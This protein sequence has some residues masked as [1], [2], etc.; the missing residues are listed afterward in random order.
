MYPSQAMKAYKD[1]CERFGIEVD[2]D[3]SR[4]SDSSAKEAIKT[5]VIG[6]CLHSFDTKHEDR[7]ELRGA[8]VAHLALLR[9]YKLTKAALPQ[10]LRDALTQAN[11]YAYNP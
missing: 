11:G 8:V 6:L 10:C 4:R 5:F 3:A 7:V 9:P 2:A 1:S